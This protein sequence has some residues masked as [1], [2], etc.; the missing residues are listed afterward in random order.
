MKKSILLLSVFFG[1]FISAHAQLADTVKAYLIRDFQRAKAYTQEY[2]HAMPADRYSY[3]PHDSVR[4]FAQQML[5]LSEG[6]FG[7]GSL[8]SGI[9]VPR[10]GL[11]K[12]VSPVKD[13]VV[14]VVNASYD[15][16]IDA[17]IKTDPSSFL[18]EAKMGNMGFSKLAW[19]NKVFEH[20]THH[21][22]Q[23]TIY[24]RMVGIKPPPERLF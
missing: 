11:E 16:I 21:R 8:A 24:I 19:F 9:P 5:H 20:Q 7:I 1:S 23:T 14:A 13:S 6:N 12:G 3:R 4:T 15:F 2:L 18:T 17:L 22:G 10:R